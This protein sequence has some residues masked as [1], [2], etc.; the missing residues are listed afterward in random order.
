MAQAAALSSGGANLLMLAAPLYMMQLYDRVLTT[1]S[2]DTLLVL[3][4]IVVGALAAHSGE[5]D[6]PFRDEAD[7]RIR[8]RRSPVGAMRRGA[9]MMPCSARHGS[10][11]SDVFAW[12]L[13]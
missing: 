12:S 10:R 2:I 5:A 9:V 6:H 13:P 11:R 4:V 7:H 8:S 3:T 1:G